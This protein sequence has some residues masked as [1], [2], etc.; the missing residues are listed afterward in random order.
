MS[1]FDT[2]MMILGL[3]D[4]EYDIPANEVLKLNDAVVNQFDEVPD[5]IFI[6]YGNSKRER[7][8]DYKMGKKRIRD[9]LADDYLH[10]SACRLFEPDNIRD[11]AFNTSVRTE[12]YGLP[13]EFSVCW[14]AERHK[15]F[16]IPSLVK[17]FC[18]Y[19]QPVYGFA[20]GMP[21]H[22]G[23]LH[24]LWGSGLYGAP[25]WLTEN[26]HMFSRAL[27]SG[28]IRAGRFR[29]IFPINI[30]SPVHMKA[31]VGGIEFGDWIAEGG[32]G[33]LMQ[34]SSQTWIW[35]VGGSSEIDTVNEVM[36]K[37]G[38]MISD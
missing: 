28:Q 5:K 26:N 34:I 7:A 4:W 13:R 37:N 9:G 23:P 14:E 19:R 33:T 31:Q 11:L 32:H 35:C 30:L 15:D 18:Q 24:C 8:I 2:Q 29:A 10:I 27:R 6:G 25:E 17:L 36:K 16:D 12:H 21:F 1:Y 22:W 38:L 3:Y 20:A